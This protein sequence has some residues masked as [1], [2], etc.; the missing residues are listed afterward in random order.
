[1]KKVLLAALVMVGTVAF[2]QKKHGGDFH[3]GK[4]NS[5]ERMKQELSLTDDQYNKVKALNEKYASEF[6]AIRQ[7]TS[8]TRG[9]AKSKMNSLK[10][11]R[12][13]E[14]KKT[15]TSEQWTKWT[16]HKSRE[17][18]SA[19]RMKQALSLTDDQY[20]K[21][22]AINEKYVAKYSTVKTEQ[23]ADLKKVLTPEQWKKWNDLSAK[24]LHGYK[25]YPKNHHRGDHDRN[26]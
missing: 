19:D 23:E 9:R 6:S 14:L 15:L 7:D 20:S 11:E 25:D 2:A 3:N 5:A 12:K 1:M 18:V 21:V 26:R 10:T 8:L 24:R 16:A 4:R 17:A 22:K 13:A